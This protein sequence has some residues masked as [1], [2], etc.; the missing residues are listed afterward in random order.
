M[1]PRT[2][3]P[4]SP[5]ATTAVIVKSNSK[6]SE[7]Y[8]PP[9][10]AAI[11]NGRE[12]VASSSMLTGFGTNSSLAGLG[13]LGNRESGK[14]YRVGTTEEFVFPGGVPRDR[15]D[16]KRLFVGGKGVFHNLSNDCK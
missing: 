3:R 4:T 8:E 5:D 2:T 1:I 6:R 10:I 14:G 12:S 9:T 7:L 11:A 15:L 16:C 13:G